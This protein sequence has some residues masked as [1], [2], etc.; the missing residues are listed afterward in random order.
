MLPASPHPPSRPA[1]LKGYA[2]ALALILAGAAASCS[3]SPPA[4]PTGS[5]SPPTRIL[6]FV[7]YSQG[8]ALIGYFSLVDSATNQIATSG[9]LRIEVYK[10]AGLKI[11]NSGSSLRIKNPFYDNSF[12]IG[13]SN[14]HW[15]SSGTIFSVNDLVC[16]FKVPYANFQ[17]PVRPG[18][19]YQ[20]RIEFY[21]DT[22]QDQ[23]LSSERNVSLY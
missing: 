12:A 8:K 16:R 14:F 6:K 20:V 22:A 1:S 21:P 23:A 17:V 7:P 10:M 19:V 2:G 5:K 15:E 18:Q 3:F 13:I 11:G 9:R 4:A